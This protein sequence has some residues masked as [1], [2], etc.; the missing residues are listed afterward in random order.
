MESYLF[1]FFLFEV[2]KKWSKP[3]ITLLIFYLFVIYF[4]G[5]TVRLKT[6]THKQLFQFQWSPRQRLF[7]YLSYVLNY[8][9]IEK[10]LLFLNVWDKYIGLLEDTT[11]PNKITII[12]FILER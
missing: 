1:I 10:Y 7:L 4:S 5:H 3:T 11:Y 2:L 12:I 6:G 8:S 9:Y